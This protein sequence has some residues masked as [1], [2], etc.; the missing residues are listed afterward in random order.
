MGYKISWELKREDYGRVLVMRVYIREG[1]DCK[2]SV[3]PGDMLDTVSNY[4]APRIRKG[5]FGGEVDIGG[6]RNFIQ[7]IKDLEI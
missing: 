1:L 2:D 5:A 6:Q 7:T 4:V 3:T